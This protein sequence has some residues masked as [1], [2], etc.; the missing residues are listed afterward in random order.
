MSENFVVQIANGNSV[1]NK[2]A[3]VLNQAG[4]APQNPILR[5]LGMAIDLVLAPT[6][7]SFEALFGPT[8]PPV[9]SILLFTQIDLLH[10]RL[11]AAAGFGS[12]MVSRDYNDPVAHYLKTQLVSSSHVVCEERL[13]WVEQDPLIELGICS[14]SS[15]QSAWAVR[16][17]EAYFQDDL[18]EEFGLTFDPGNVDKFRALLCT[19]TYG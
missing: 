13:F 14:G 18:T 12:L 16:A 10:Y 7:I 8:T 15:L 5:G 2:I 4:D 9:D 19:L 11:R 6:V 3:L 1:R 17:S